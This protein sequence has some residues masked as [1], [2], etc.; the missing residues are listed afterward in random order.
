[1]TSDEKLTC[2][3]GWTGSFHFVGENALLSSYSKLVFFINCW[4]INQDNI[5]TSTLFFMQ[6]IRANNHHPGL[7]LL[8]RF[9]NEKKINTV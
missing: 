1:M 6:L 9:I 7:N 2:L 8:K 3:V 5:Q 4:I